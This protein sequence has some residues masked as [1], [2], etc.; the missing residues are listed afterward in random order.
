M[1][2]HTPASDGLRTGIYSTTDKFRE[3]KKHHAVIAGYNGALIA[4][5]GP[6]GGSL[7]AVSL[8]NARLY[9][10]A[11]K[12]LEIVEKFIDIVESA[13][14]ETYADELSL[15]RDTVEKA[16]KGDLT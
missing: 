2:K 1:S 16:M 4:V 15:A 8:A 3:V 11:P 14:P 7:D 6:V 10:A 13:G 9:A 12:L 5:T